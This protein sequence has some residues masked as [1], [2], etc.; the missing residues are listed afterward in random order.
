MVSPCRAYSLY[1]R[2]KDSWS[3]LSFSSEPPRGTDE[4]QNDFFRSGSRIGGGL[5]NATATPS[6]N[7]GV[8]STTKL[9]SSG[10]RPMRSRSRMNALIRSM[11]RWVSRNSV[12]GVECRF[13][14]SSSTSRTVRLI[15][16]SPVSTCR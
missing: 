9:S 14:T 10:G 5:K 16:S 13:V 11:A 12:S 2:R 1:S 6:M 8:G 7:P 15:R 3:A 4:I